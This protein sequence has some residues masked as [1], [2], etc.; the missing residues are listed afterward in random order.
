MVTCA[1]VFDIRRSQVNVLSES[2]VICIVS[3]PCT[4]VICTLS[5][6]IPAGKSNVPLKV[7][8]SI[9]FHVMFSVP[10]CCESFMAS[11]GVTPSLLKRYAHTVPPPLKGFSTSFSSVYLLP[12]RT[13]GFLTT[14]LT[15]PSYSPKTPPSR[16]LIERGMTICSCV[17]RFLLFVKAP[18]QMRWMPLPCSS[19]TNWIEDSP[20][21]M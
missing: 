6:V 14:T 12:N 21:L 3:S 1:S 4:T 15:G 9:Q 11:E 13:S 8:V 20:W 16:Y 19:V 17:L 10:A 18:P 7:A 2:G 5:T